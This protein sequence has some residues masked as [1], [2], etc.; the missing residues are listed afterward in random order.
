MKIFYTFIL[1]TFVAL[2]ANSQIFEGKSGLISDNNQ[3][4][5]FDLNVNKIED[6]TKNFGFENIKLDIDHSWNSDLDIFL[7]APDGTKARLVQ[8]N[9]GSSQNYK[10]TIFTMNAKTSI[11]DTDAPF[12]GEFKPQNDHLGIF[13][14]SENLSGKWQL[15]ITDTYTGNVGKLNSWSVS[16]GNK[17]A[18]ALLAAPSC[19]LASAATFTC[20]S[21]PLICD[22]GGYCGETVGSHVYAWPALGSA[23]GGGAFCGGIQNNSFIKFIA[24]APT[25][26]F[27]VWITSQVP[28]GS[29]D[30]SGIQMMVFETTA[31]GSGSVVSHGCLNRMAPT[32]GGNNGTPTVFTATS[33][34]VGNTYYLMFDG[35]GGDECSFIVS[36]QAGVNA[37]NVSPPSADICT[38]G[39]S[40]TLTASGS[41]GYTWTSN[42]AGFTGAG[43]SVTVAPLVT[44]TYTINSTSACVPKTVTVTVGTFNINANPPNLFFCSSGTPTYD[45]TSNN[46]SI[47]GSLNPV[48]YDINFFHSLADA[49]L[50]SNP[51]INPNAY[52]PIVANEIIYVRV[53]EIS[54][55]ACVKIASFTLTTC[56]PIISNSGPICSNASFNLFANTAAT[57]INF[58]WSGPNGFT[59]NQQNPTNIPAPTGSA[60]FV[61]TLTCT[62]AVACTAFTTLMVNPTPNAGTANFTTI[63][64]TDF[65]IINLFSILNGSPQSG[66]TW[67]RILGSGGIFNAI[68]GSFQSDITTTP[69]SSFQYT[70]SNSCGTSTSIVTVNRIIIPPTVILNNPTPLSICDDNAVA[71][72]IACFDANTL[73]LHSKDNEVNTDPTIIISYHITFT[74]ATL[75]ANPIGGTAAAPSSYCNIN[76][77]AQRIYV[78]GGNSIDPTK[79]ATTVL[80]LIV[81]PRPLQNLLLTPFEL[82]NVNP[83][84]AGSTFLVENFNLHNKDLDIING[85]ISISPIVVN[86]YNNQL[87]AVGDL[88]GNRINNIYSNTANPQTIYYNI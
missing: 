56:C 32:V 66:G 47:L 55:G 17:P 52:Q 25:A 50:L 22:L 4:D 61:Y 79:F 87:D 51:I 8:A 46:A 45:L 44:T 88:T 71:D 62:S 28:V 27:N 24:S 76:P 33:L 23:S 64:E 83:D 86:Y 36:S 14:R 81:N 80:D 31:C 1:T 16:F 13:N 11:Q 41:S 9:G 57:G 68:A 19:T 65:N 85:Q 42:P 6:N 43:A 48:D 35:Y 75:G 74:D 82:C 5:L 3:E 84:P 39:Q 10:N 38:P 69:V 60:P 21:A 30:P 34:I 72:G 67:I 73:F 78:R 15:S 12:T 7:I 37:I 63:Q 29:P 18:V 58:A 59:S 40:V 26:N 70:V 53:E 77:F 54:G 2:F 20:A 49:N